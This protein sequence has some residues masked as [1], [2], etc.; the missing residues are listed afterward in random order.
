MND[1]KQHVDA[2]STLEG[3]QGRVPEGFVANFL[4]VMTEQTFIEHHA[5]SNSI[6]AAGAD[7]V[8][9]APCVSD[10]EPFFEFAAIYDAV[11]AAKG[12]FTMVELGGGFASRCVDAH[13]A[14][15]RYNPLPAFFVVVEAEPTHFQWAKRHMRKNGI[16]PD[17]NWMINCAVSDG[18]DPVLF[19]TGEGVFY[20]S[21]VGDHDREDIFRQIADMNQAT[22]VLRNLICAGRLGANI[23]YKS[24]AGE[25]LHDMKYVSARPLT[26]ILQPLETVDL[27]DVDIQGAEISVLP[28]ALKVLNGKVKRL[29]LGTHS[30][31]IHKFMWEMFFEN[32]WI[33]EYDYA[34]NADIDTPWG[35]FRTSDGILSLVNSRF[36]DS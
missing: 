34:P 22:P 19:L 27:L 36:P 17:S 26:D 29:H 16:D 14:L 35:S 15:G 33:C 11:L 6:V 25:H 24:Q 3:W 2:F 1:L 13:A 32:E 20:N 8:A 10:G 23:P 9:Q 7:T 4:G 12:R 21:I 18:A 31:E 28:P 30:P 5:P